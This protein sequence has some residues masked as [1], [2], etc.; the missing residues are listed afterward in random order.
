MRLAVSVSVMPGAV[1]PLVGPARQQ[2]K[3]IGIVRGGEDLHPQESRRGVDQVWSL[4]ERAAYFARRFIRN[5][6]AADDDEC[7]HEGPQL[8]YDSN[9]GTDSLA[10]C[11]SGHVLSELWSVREQTADC[12]VSSSEAVR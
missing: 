7:S 5:F 8:K 1:A 12:R 3:L 9:S 10:R 6:E 2:P 11:N 4:E